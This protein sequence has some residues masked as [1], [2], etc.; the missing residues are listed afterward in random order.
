MEE[1]VV[2]RMRMD[3]LTNL[4]AEDDEPSTEHQSQRN[5]FYKM[6]KTLALIDKST[7]GVGI[8]EINKPV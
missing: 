3:S 6:H 1:A 2:M 7:T 5:Q 4:T 8:D